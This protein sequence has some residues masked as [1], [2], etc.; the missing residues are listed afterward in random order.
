MRNSDQRSI[1]DSLAARFPRFAPTTIGRWVASEAE[2]YQS[3]KVQ[4]YV[5]VLVEK[6]V[7]SRLLDLTRI[8]A[9]PL[10][11]SG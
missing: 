6:S 10:V 8:P 9:D 3:A 11:T 4:A 5:P 7:A 1:E 2:K